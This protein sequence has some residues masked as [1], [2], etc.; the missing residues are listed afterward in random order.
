[1]GLAA[2]QARFLGLTARKSNI[3]YQGQQINQARTALSNEV[4]NLYEKYNKLDV[5]VP[6]SVN[7][8]TKTIYTVDSTQENYEISNFSKITSGPDTGYYNLT[9]RYDDEVPTP[10]SYTAK[11][12]IA[13]SSKNSDGEY[14]KINITIGTDTYEY[15]GATEETRGNSTFFRIKGEEEIKKYADLQT[16]INAG[17]FSKDDTEF[18]RYIK[19]N[20]SYYTSKSELDSAFSGTGS[21]H[22]DYTFEYQGIQKQS[23]TISAVGAL[24]QEA[25]GRLSAVTI[26]ECKE[27]PNLENTTHSITTGT[28]DD[29][30]A[31]EDAMNQYYYNKQKYEREVEIINKKTEKI[32]SQD[33][34]LE[35]KLNQLDTEQKAISTEMDSITKVIEDTIDSVFKTFNS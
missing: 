10:Y 32:Q 26:V 31:Y 25:S 18:Y 30:K 22:G 20:T 33:K 24:T 4:M 16:L 15:N 5:P 35:L 14:E 13:S 11:N 3:E 9:L 17:K 27:D 34:A 6:P 21:Y 2:S 8:Y 29:Q 7:S 1:M 12:M 23:K 19:N 28:Q